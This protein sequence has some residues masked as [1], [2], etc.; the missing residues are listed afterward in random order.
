M[1]GQ[2]SYDTQMIKMIQVRP[3][4]SLYKCLN[5]TSPHFLLLLPSLPLSVQ[6]A[7]KNENGERMVEV[8]EMLHLEKSLELAIRIADHYSLPQVAK[9]I[10]EVMAARIQPSMEGDFYPSSPRNTSTQSGLSSNSPQGNQ[11]RRRIICLLVH[12]LIHFM[13]RLVQVALPRRKK[14]IKWK[15]QMCQPLNFGTSGHVVQRQQQQAEK[16]IAKP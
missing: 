5:N 9:K 3:S 11:P 2:A 10:S 6:I 1:R 13:L 8:A 14:M 7:A 15:R 16:I 12:F 4:V